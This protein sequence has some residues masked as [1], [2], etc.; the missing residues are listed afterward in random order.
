MTSEEKRDMY[1][2]AA[3]GGVAL[4][5]IL[6]Y[7]HTPPQLEQTAT[8]PDATQSAA[9]TGEQTPYNYNVQPYGGSGSPFYVPPAGAVSRPAN[10][11]VSGGGC[12]DPCASNKGP[13][14]PGITAYLKLLALGAA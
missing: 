14:S 2:A 13:D 10:S 4:V 9:D 5:L 1:I 6:L 11:N 8:L 3:V 7:I 12:C